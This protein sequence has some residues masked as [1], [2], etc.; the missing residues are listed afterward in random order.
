MNNAQPNIKSLLA[1]QENKLLVEKKNKTGS[2]AWESP[3]GCILKNHSRNANVY[4]ATRAGE[5][6]IN[7]S[8]DKQM[9]CRNLDPH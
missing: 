3:E 7:K 1:S 5:P 4:L 9:L 2:L 8:I 6:N